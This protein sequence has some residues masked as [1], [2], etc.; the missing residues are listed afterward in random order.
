LSLRKWDGGVTIGIVEQRSCDRRTAGRVVETLGL[1]G[2]LAV[3]GDEV[4]VEVEVQVEVE[5][6]EGGE[7]G[8]RGRAGGS[9][10][11]LAASGCL[12]AGSFCVACALAAADL[13]A[14]RVGRLPP[15]LFMFSH[16]LA[17]IRLPPGLVSIGASAFRGCRSLVTVNL[18]ECRGLTAVEDCAFSDCTALSRIQVPDS[19]GC[20][21]AEAF[22]WTDLVCFSVGS[23]DVLVGA[24]AF[25]G[26]RRLRTVVSGGCA[27]WEGEVFEACEAL[28]F[29]NVGQLVEVDERAL[30]GSNREWVSRI[31]WPARWEAAL[32]VVVR[33]GSDVV[34]VVWTETERPELQAMSQLTVMRQVGDLS[35]VQRRQVC[36]IDMRC[37][38][39][40]P[41][42]LTLRDCFFLERALLPITL[43]KLPPEFF[44][45]CGQLWQV[46]LFECSHLERLGRAAF[47]GCWKLADLHLPFSCVHIDLGGCG[48][49]DLDLRGF[50]CD[51]VCVVCCPY[52]GRIVLPHAFGGHLSHGPGLYLSSLTTGN[53]PFLPPGLCPYEVRFSSCWQLPCRA[54]AWALPRVLGEVA[55]LGGVETRPCLAL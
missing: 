51:H 30:V 50:A 19:L 25:R 47:S 3:S 5:V 2:I 32:K 44:A 53:S 39:G 37:L 12:S 1:V 18:A 29:V 52:L 14:S 38:E 46:N 4:E 54:T 15:C 26:C 48:V 36:E 45:D 49:T 9:P 34:G 13:S 43:M 27:R 20:I 28:T 6:R 23:S 11:I 10:Y 7:G 21:G 33:P 55:A 24:G 16:L 42:G 35:T 8:P 41:P 22:A 17:F 31:A 40:L